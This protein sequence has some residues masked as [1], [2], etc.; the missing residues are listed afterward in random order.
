MLLMIIKQ[1]THLLP[2]I[3]SLTY[4]KMFNEMLCWKLSLLYTV[5]SVGDI[6]AEKMITSRVEVRFRILTSL[7][8]FL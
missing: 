3:R 1:R 7:Q 4:V 8:D 6:A 5:H 2:V